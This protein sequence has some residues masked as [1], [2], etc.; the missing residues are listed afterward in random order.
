MRWRKDEG[1]WTLF[2]NLPQ[3]HQ[4][5]YHLAEIRDSGIYEERMNRIREDVMKTL[6]TADENGYRFVLF[7]HGWSTSERWKT[8]TARSVVRGVMRSPEATPFIIRRDCIQHYT[9]FV[10]AVRPK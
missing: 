3:L 5:N 10:A 9:A 1:D 4:V 8:T 7:N 2:R 6:R